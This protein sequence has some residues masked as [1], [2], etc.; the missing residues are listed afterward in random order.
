MSQIKNI[1]WNYRMIL[2]NKKSHDK[3]TKGIKVRKAFTVALS[4]ILCL[5]CFT[6]CGKDENKSG[7][8]LVFTTGFGKDE[9]F[10]IEDATCTKGEL[11]VYLTTTQNQ[12]EDVYGTE[13]WNVSLD[14][15]TLEENVKD[16]VLAKAAQIKTMYLLAKEK[17]IALEEAE[18]KQVEEAAEEYF[19]SLNETEIELMGITQD[20]VEKLYR[21][22]AMADKVY[23]NIIQDVNPEISDDEARIITVQHILVRTSRY[24]G[25][26]NK[27]Q[28]ADSAREAVYEKACEV[29]ELAVDGKSDF[30]ELA[31]KYSE[32]TNITYSFGMGEADKVY[33]EAAF[34][35][36]TDEVSEVIETEDGYYIIKC[37][38]TFNREETDANKLKIVEQRKNEV[39]GQE[40]DRFVETLVRNL[41]QDVWDEVQLIHNAEVTTSDFFEVYE[42]YFEE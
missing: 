20:T 2:K 41:N 11:M 23:H 30:T 37:V 12:Y 9:V 40:Y 34:Q 10:R 36:E 38:S 5:S 22:Y 24:D 18:E 3:N 39:F 17:D 25:A 1:E 14:D 21:E 6:A 29:R 16:T 33:E 7:T 15:V 19:Q 4:A 32:D 31:S 42:E 28:Y 8:R 26:G 35:L 13:I 27:I